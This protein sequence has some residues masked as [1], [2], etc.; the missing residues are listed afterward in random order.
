MAAVL[1]LGGIGASAKEAIPALKQALK[2]PQTAYDAKQAIAR[3]N[4]N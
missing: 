4:Q 2:D 1:G 3:I